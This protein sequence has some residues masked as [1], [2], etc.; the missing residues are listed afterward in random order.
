MCVASG[1][2]G[3]QRM[4]VCCSAAAVSSRLQQQSQLPWAPFSCSN[5]LYVRALR[6]CKVCPLS[7]L[8]A[9]GPLVDPDEPLRGIPRPLRATS[10][11]PM[12]APIRI[13]SLFSRDF[14]AHSVGI[15]QPI[16][17]TNFFY[18]LLVKLQQLV[19]KEEADKPQ[20]RLGGPLPPLG[21]P[22][23]PGGPLMTITGPSKTLTGPLQPNGAL[24]RPQGA[25]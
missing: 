9:G 22:R 4:R 15:H 17:S 21:A 11:A 14:Y 24:W 1:A 25:P 6:R 16:F 18:Y 19:H 13:C 20:N 12:G 5:E 7:L 8:Q 10:G 23:I 3:M 2:R